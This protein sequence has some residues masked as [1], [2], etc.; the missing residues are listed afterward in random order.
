M[1]KNYRYINRQSQ[2][3]FFGFLLTSQHWLN[4]SQ[5]V[6]MVIA[7]DAANDDHINIQQ[8][9]FY[10]LFYQLGCCG[11]LGHERHYKALHPREM[12]KK[13]GALKK[14]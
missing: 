3:L 4:I 9:V 5:L 11:Y 12:L 1:W 7:L 8:S 10:S 6:F 13:W 2:R 14:I